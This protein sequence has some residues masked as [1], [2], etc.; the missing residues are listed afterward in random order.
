MSAPQRWRNRFLEHVDMPAD[1]LPP[2]RRLTPLGSR[3]NVVAAQNLREPRDSVTRQMYTAAGALYAQY[4][5]IA[6]SS[7]SRPVYEAI[8]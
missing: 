6:V 5:T 3:C 7:R 8:Q 2:A 1:E 4:V